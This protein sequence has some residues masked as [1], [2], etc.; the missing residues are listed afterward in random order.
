MTEK[1]S[2]E[3]EGNFRVCARESEIGNQCHF[4]SEGNFFLSNLD[5]FVSYF[6]FA[7]LFP[8]PARP[9]VREQKVTELF[10][11]FSAGEKKRSVFLIM[12]AFFVPLHFI[13]HASH[14]GKQVL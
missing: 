12:P 13:T 11:L 14:G 6:L 8:P 1:K 7:S 3:K 9:E 10:L 4:L 5:F 2:C